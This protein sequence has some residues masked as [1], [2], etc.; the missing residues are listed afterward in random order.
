M[1]IS[2]NKQSFKL[3]ST[4]VSDVDAVSQTPQGGAMV[5]RC[6]QLSKAYTGSPQFEKISFNLCK[7]QR[8]GLIGV[9]GAGKSTLLRCLAQIDAADSGLVE[10]ASNSN[11]VYVDQEP[12]WG[13][14]LV[15][16]ALFTGD[17]LQATATR[18][19]FRLLDP[20]ATSIDDDIFSKISDKM[21]ASNGWEYQ[22]R[23]ISIAEK[24]NI[25]NEFL[26]RN[27]NTLSGG[28]KKRVGLSAA[29]LKQPDVLLLDEV[30]M[31]NNVEMKYYILLVVANQSP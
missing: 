19:Y 12:D 24:L 30:C 13:S 18:D 8:V 26:Y 5:L 15:F 27:V 23:G 2:A 25:P 20:S 17:S 7:G 21:E 11:V 4:K 31:D 14:I 6:E 29:L 22:E 1:W 28:E 16:E 9:N 3:D 10:V